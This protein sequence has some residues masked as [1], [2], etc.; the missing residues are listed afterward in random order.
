[1]LART[2]GVYA[3]AV[4]T[5]LWASCEH[6]Y[7]HAPRPCLVAARPVKDR[8]NSCCH[9]RGRLTTAARGRHAI[10]HPCFRDFQITRRLTLGDVLPLSERREAFPLAARRNARCG[11]GFRYYSR[12]RRG[13]P[14]WDAL[15]PDMITS[16]WPSF[17]VSSNYN[18]GLTRFAATRN[19]RQN[20]ELI[21]INMTVVGVAQAGFVTA[22]SSD[23]AENLIPH[24][25]PAHDHRRNPEDML[26]ERRNRWGMPSAALA[27]IPAA[28]Q[29]RPPAVQCTPCSYGGAL[30]AFRHASA[31]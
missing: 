9:M 31:V 18:Y 20:F 16:P 4:R 13:R 12:S 6:R 25:V 1:M 23:L 26:K 3:V 21:I 24:H 5:W 15:T 28:L 27:E 11:I 7:Y 17:V 10:S 2:P 8:S 14:H 30:P 22:W 29:G 19:R